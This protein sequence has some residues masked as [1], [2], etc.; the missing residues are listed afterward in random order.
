MQFIDFRACTSREGIEAEIRRLYEKRFLTPE[1]AAS[2]DAGR[3]L[4]FFSSPLG[5]RMM[6]SGRINREFKFSLLASCA[7]TDDLTALAYSP[8]TD[9]DT[10]LFQGVIDCYFEEPAGI[11]LIDFKRTLSCRAVNGFLPNDTGSN[12]PRMHLH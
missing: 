12:L 9:D 1:Q 3:I 11:I 7:M 10:L 6:S 2:V 5:I 8:N 4:A